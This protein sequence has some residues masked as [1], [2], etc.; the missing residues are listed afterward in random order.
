MPT[1]ADTWKTVEWRYY[2]IPDAIPALCNL[3][4]EQMVAKGWTQV[5]WSDPDVNTSVSNWIRGEKANATGGAM[6]Y[7]V[8][9]GMGAFVAIARSTP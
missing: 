8:T 7:V 1:P 6:I 4:R 9:W 3:Y 2:E 5:S